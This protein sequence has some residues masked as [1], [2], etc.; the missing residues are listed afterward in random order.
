MNVITNNEERIITKHRKPRRDACPGPCD[1]SLPRS[2]R[3]SRQTEPTSVVE[4]NR[5]RS[6]PP[7]HD[8]PSSSRE[9]DTT[10]HPAQASGDVGSTWYLFKDDEILYTSIVDG[11]NVPR[12]TILQ[13]VRHFVYHPLNVTSKN[14][15]GFEYSK[16]PLRLYIL[17]E[18]RYENFTV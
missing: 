9:R 8:S 2:R 17:C 5:R 10:T 11:C 13:V 1:E 16:L 15:P 14:W 18:F 4:F 7:P 3:D 6:L 12:M